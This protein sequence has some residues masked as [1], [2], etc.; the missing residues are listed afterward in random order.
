MTTLPLRAIAAAAVLAAGTAFA[1]WDRPFDS[2]LRAT[3]SQTLAQ[4]RQ[5][6]GWGGRVRARMPNASSYDGAFTYCR[7]V[8]TS[9]RR[10]GSG[11]GW[12][13]DY[14]DADINFSIR[15][16][17]LTK[18]TISRQSDNEP[19]HL[20]VPI[21]DPY[22]FQC[23]F[24]MMT[25]VGEI[26]ISAQEVKILR[27][28]LD[29]GGFLWVDDFWGSWSWSAWESEI[30]KVLPPGQF[31][32]RDLTPDH[33]IFRTLF[34]ITKLPQIPSIN[35]WRGM[36]GGTSELGDDS[37]EPH[38]RAITNS[39]GRMMVLMTHNTDISDAWEREAA[40]PQYFLEFSPLGYTVGLNV[41]LYAAT[42]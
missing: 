34:E 29:K 16:S 3:G 2:G 31:P 4:G 25:D 36:G 10:D 35:S 21:T 6:W 28:Y 38:I 22:F 27:D 7:G 42:H 40:D 12:T 33:P 39:D 1:Q 15:L 18:T 9:G 17:E 19:N 14:P 13:T 20:T 41:F 8:Y 11:N 23:P 30:A 37:A 26:L 5:G 24:V 32:I